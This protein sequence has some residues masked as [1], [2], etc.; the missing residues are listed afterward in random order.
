MLSYNSSS[1]KAVQ[2]GQEITE[3]GRRAVAFQCD[4]G[5]SAQCDDLARKAEKAFGQI[6][7]LISN[8]GMGQGNGIAKTP[9]EEWERTMNVNARA[10]FCL[11]RALLPGMVE[12][13]FGRVVTISSNVGVYGRGGASG[14]AYAA[15]KAALI[16]V[17]KGIAHEGAPHVTAN[18]IL[19]GPTSTDHPNDRE[20]PVEVVEGTEPNVTRTNIFG[21]WAALLR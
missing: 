14:I 15:S 19:P 16:A 10:S 11:A 7:V 12:R 5:D 20:E 9:D 13:K 1:D 17:T 4:V 2:I 18:C 3:M 21:I 8:A 6:D